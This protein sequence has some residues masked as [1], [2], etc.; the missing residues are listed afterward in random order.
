V[1]SHP[2]S[3]APLPTASNAPHRSRVCLAR[4]RIG[5]GCRATK[6]PALF[7]VVHD[8]G[9]EEDLDEEEV[10][11]AGTDYDSLA[12]AENRWLKVGSTLLGER[13]ARRFG[14]QTVVGRVTHWLPA[15][16]GNG[17]PALFRIVHD[18]GDKEELDEDEL[19]EARRAYAAAR[20]STEDATTWRHDGHE[21]VGR[22]VAREFG[23]SVVFGT[24]TKW[25]A[26]DAAAGEPAL[27]HAVHDDG[28]AEDLEEEEAEE[29]AERFDEEEMSR[30]DWLRDGHPLVGTRVARTFGKRTVLGTVVKWLAASEQAAEPAL[31]RVVHDDG[32]EE[33]L[34]EEEAQEAAAK[35]TAMPER[36]T[37]SR[38]SRA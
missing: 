11:E 3:R 29:A 20:P 28:D 24:I 19:S 9:D 34:E 7:R 6:E 21:L 14:E 5:S 23:R 8:D 26:A 37:C 10:S 27:F 1:S 32:D 12:P 18:D 31:F 22:R 15:D 4:A 30:A 16:V 36:R 35:F 13:V 2:H 38:L 33:D 17:E 25:L